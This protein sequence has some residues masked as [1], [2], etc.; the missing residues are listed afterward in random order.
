MVFK[1]KIIISVTTLLFSIALASQN[2][3]EPELRALAQEFKDS[4]SFNG[5]LLV[6]S[7][8][9]I[10]LE[11]SYGFADYGSKIKNNRDTKFRIASISK[12]FVS[13]AIFILADKGL[14]SLDDTIGAYLPNLNSEFANNITIKNLLDHKSGLPRSLTQISGKSTQEYFNNSEIIDLINKSNIQITKDRT[15]SYSNIG[16]SLLALTIESI[17]KLSFENAMKNLVFNPLGLDNTGH[18][19]ESEIIENLARGYD[20]LGG[21]IYNG[22]HENKSHV[23]GAG[24]LY[25][26]THDLWK[27]AQEIIEGSLLSKKMHQL[28]ITE[29]IKNKTQG[30]WVTWKYRAELENQPNAGQIL[31]FNGSCPG[32]RSVISIYLEHKIVVIGLSNQYPMNPS[33]V[34]NKFGNVALGLKRETVYKPLI[35]EL[36][37]PITEGKFELAIKIYNVSMHKKLGSNTISPNE[38]NQMGYAFL[39]HNKITEAINIFKFFV[40]IHPSNSNAY[41]SLGEALIVGG[42]VEEGVKMY[43]K[44][45][46]IDPNNISAKQIVKKYTF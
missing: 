16:Y 30:G 43:K 15:S 27:F 31:M 2:R 33:L 29:V 17:T 22:A 3:Q 46:A 45:L 6:T 19:V 25:S 36:L 32:Y 13:Y 21:K 37:T 10:L 14:L 12:M 23:I 24:S 4:V 11:K 20:N 5:N 28:Y 44:S 34:F 8:G 9:K 42:F 35:S 38:F 41:D 18:E 39:G 1:S 26:T 40:R 7:K